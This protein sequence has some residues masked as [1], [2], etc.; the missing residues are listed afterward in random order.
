MTAAAA[1]WLFMAFAAAVILLM[2]W[3]QRR[4][5]PA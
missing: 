5:Q 1:S 4:S 2:F 3:L